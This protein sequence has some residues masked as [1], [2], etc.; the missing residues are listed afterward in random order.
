MRHHGVDTCHIPSD[1][2]LHPCMPTSHHT[3]PTSPSLMQQAV[4][5]TVRSNHPIKGSMAIV[6]PRSYPYKRCNPSSEKELAHGN[7]DE[8]LAIRRSG[9]RSGKRQVTWRGLPLACCAVEASPSASH[10]ARIGNWRGSDRA[11]PG[12]CERTV[13]NVHLI[14]GR[15][16]TGVTA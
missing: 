3:H 5:R 16:G 11:Q 2:Q 15:G 4:K 13:I 10:G 9:R 8:K 14:V 7:E 1:V 6:Q 12:E